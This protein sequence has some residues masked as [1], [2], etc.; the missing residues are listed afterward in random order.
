[1]VKADHTQWAQ[2]FDAG[3]QPWEREVTGWV[4]S[5]A[6]SN[7]HRGA[8]NTALFFETDAPSDV[9]GFM[10]LSA[11]VLDLEDDLVSQALKLTPGS[12]PRRREVAAAHIAFLGVPKDKQHRGYGSSMLADLFVGL[13]D[14]FISPRFVV[15]KV[16]A[17]SPAVKLYELLGFVE[18][19]DPISDNIGWGVNQPGQLRT[20]VFDRFS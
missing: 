11:S 7:H 13:F 19:G 9:V 20:M 4:Q 16:W 8:T 14:D 15:L 17:I 5:G 2:S 6:W 3:P 12:R 1:M 18:I 10:S